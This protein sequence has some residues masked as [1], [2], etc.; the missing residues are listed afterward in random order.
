M[1]EQDVEEFTQAGNCRRMIIQVARWQS[2]LLELD[3]LSINEILQVCFGG[4]KR[5]VKFYKMRL[6]DERE[7]AAYSGQC[8]ERSTHQSSITVSSR[9]VGFKIDSHDSQS[10]PLL[11]K[12]LGGIPGGVLASERLSE[13]GMIVN[14]LESIVIEKG[15]RWK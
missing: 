10:T 2:P 13:R 9:C 7:E 12:F 11:N 3:R 5:F 1:A 4:S 15:G 8:D 14:H 6:D